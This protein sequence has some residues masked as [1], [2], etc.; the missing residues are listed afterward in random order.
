ML[1]T[2]R[3]E[4]ISVGYR[5]LTGG[6]GERE[7]GVERGATGKG[8]HENTPLGG[9]GADGEQ[10]AVTYAGTLAVPVCGNAGKINPTACSILRSPRGA[11]RRAQEGERPEH[12]ICCKADRSALLAGAAPAS[13]GS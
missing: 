11:L 9:A 10:I 6:R 3:S 7:R 4:V 12:Q 5:G 8:F 13:R 1:M 2:E